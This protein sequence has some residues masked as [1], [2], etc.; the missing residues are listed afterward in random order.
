MRKQIAEKHCLSVGDEKCHSNITVVIVLDIL[1]V[2]NV[3]G[4]TGEKNAPTKERGGSKSATL[5]RRRHLKIGGHN[6][7]KALSSLG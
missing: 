4:G 7:S 6:T 3:E 1:I 5:G 2:Q